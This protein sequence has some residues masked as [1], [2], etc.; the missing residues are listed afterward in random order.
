MQSGGNKPSQGARGTTRGVSIHIG[1]NHVDSNEYQDENGDPWDGALAGC[2]NDA[3]AMQEI[4]VAQGYESTLLIDDQ[5][6]S[7]QVLQSI[8]QAAQDLSAGD[9][10]LLTYSGHGGQVPDVNGDEDEAQDETWC[11]FDRMVIDD[12][13]YQM[14]SQFEAG[15]RI[16]VLSDSCHSGTVLKQT[17]YSQISLLPPLMKQYERGKTGA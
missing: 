5:A 14:W 6:T 17:I 15:V 12:E 10:L 13:L 16:F 9:I 7:A 11:L 3:R 1:L 4:A 8:G 2:I